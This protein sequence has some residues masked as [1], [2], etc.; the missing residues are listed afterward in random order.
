MYLAIRVRSGRS[1]VGGGHTHSTGATMR[2]DDPAAVIDDDDV[3]SI[4]RAIVYAIESPEL[5]PRIRDA[6]INALLDKRNKA[7][8]GA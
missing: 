7:T 6:F 8:L 4:D 2:Q 3:D 1:H 5:D